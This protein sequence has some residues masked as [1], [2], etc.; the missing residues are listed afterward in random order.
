MHRFL[1]IDELMF[2]FARSEK[3]AIDLELLRKKPMP[4]YL[5]FSCEIIFFSFFIGGF[6]NSIILGFTILGSSG[7]TM[8]AL[9]QML[10]NPQP[11]VWG[12]TILGGLATFLWASYIDT[13]LGTSYIAVLLSFLMGRI[14]Y[15]LNNFFFKKYYI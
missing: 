8:Y 15:S 14:C 7:L 2:P 5:I 3:Q 11:Y 1:T 4:I 6:A 10:Y 12:G 9:G 13:W